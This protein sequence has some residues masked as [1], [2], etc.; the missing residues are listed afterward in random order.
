M[1]GY[2]CFVTRPR[3][4]QD[5]QL[6]DS[7]EDD[8]PYEIVKTVRLSWIDYENFITDMLADRQ[9]LQEYAHLCHKSKSVIKCLH[10]KYQKANKGILVVPDGA[11]VKE[12]ALVRLS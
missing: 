11:Y 5:L 1:D 7:V 10:V 8:Q 6:L 3:T 9:F 12:A 4:I 2:A